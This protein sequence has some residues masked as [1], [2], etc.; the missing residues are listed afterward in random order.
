MKFI[1]KNNL[2][3]YKDREKTNLATWAKD[4]LTRFVLIFRIN[5]KSVKICSA[6]VAQCQ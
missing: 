2:L 1:A 4:R 5:I 6:G 3:E